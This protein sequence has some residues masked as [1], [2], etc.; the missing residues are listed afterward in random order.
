MKR[1]TAGFTLIEMMVSVA[2]GMIVLA[3][4]VRVVADHFMLLRDTT[5]TADLHRNSREVI[6][7]LSTD[8]RQAGMGIGYELNGTFAGVE[9]GNF[10]IGDATFNS[11]NQVVALTDGNVLT[12]D[13][14]VRLARGDVRSVADYSAGV[15]G[16]GQ[17]CTSPDIKSGDSVVLLSREG[18]QRRSVLLTAL[19]AETCAEDKCV[20]GCQ[21]FSFNAG[22]YAPDSASSANFQ[23]G[24][25]VGDYE[26]IGWFVTAD[27]D[28]EGELRRIKV[29]AAGGC[30]AR[31][32]TCGGTIAKGV[33][34]VQVKL[35]QWDDTTTSWSEI[36]PADPINTRNRLRFD[37]EVV[38]RA[39]DDPR[40]VLHERAASELEAGVCVPQPCDGGKLAGRRDV[41]RTS[42]EV[43]NSGRMMIK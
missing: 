36:G 10:K 37:L 29:G 17:I 7:F 27:A 42:V 26:H 11:D 13:I 41:M 5:G 20:D 28:G 16:S 33:E 8:L 21:G 15:A 38:S 24:L 14:G 6:E 35:W 34:S 22:D 19:G 12:D 30:A 3:A 18:L 40:G 32:N 4:G 1:K 2:V 9:R 39:P 25:M 31:D 23:G 43:R